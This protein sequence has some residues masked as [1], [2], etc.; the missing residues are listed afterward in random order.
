M[1]MRKSLC[2]I[3]LTLLAL[4]ACSSDNNNSSGGGS[5]GGSS[6]GGSSSGGTTSSSLS[7]FVLNLFAMDTTETAL[8][9]DLTTVALD[10]S[11]EDPAPYTP[12]FAPG[13]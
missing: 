13:G 2:L 6:S 7:A 12:L 4:A 3:P 11:S 10:T 9:T 1:R 5:S 8:P